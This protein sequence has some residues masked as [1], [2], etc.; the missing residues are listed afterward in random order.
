MMIIAAII[1]IMLNKIFVCI[2]VLGSS[3]GP[4][5]ETRKAVPVIDRKGCIAALGAILTNK[6]YKP[7][8]KK[9]DSMVVMIT[10]TIDNGLVTVG[11]TVRGMKYCSPNA[12][13][14]AKNSKLAIMDMIE[15]N[16]PNHKILFGIIFCIL[17]F[18]DIAI[19]YIPGKLFKS[20]SFFPCRHIFEEINYTFHK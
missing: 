12:F 4:P 17:L 7:V 3:I 20:F 10:I 9:A 19:N 16:I 18:L 6:L 5:K 14:K 11:D 13:V 2:N 1:C 8:A 15:T